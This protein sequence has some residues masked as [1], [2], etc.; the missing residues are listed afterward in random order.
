MYEPILFYVSIKFVYIIS[1]DLGDLEKLPQITKALSNAV[2]VYNLSISYFYYVSS[3]HII[4][5]RNHA[6]LQEGSALE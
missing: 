6:C 5:L 1:G 3:R 2:S 4:R